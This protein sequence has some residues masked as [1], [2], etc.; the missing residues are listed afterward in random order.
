MRKAL[1]FTVQGRSG[2]ANFADANGFAEHPAIAEALVLDTPYLAEDIRIRDGV[3]EA[4]WEA[5]FPPEV[6]G[7]TRL[8][9]PVHR[10]ARCVLLAACSG[11][12]VDAS[13]L[14]RATLHAAAHTFYDR[15][16]EL[17]ADAPQTAALTHREA[18]VLHWTRNGKTGSEIA[19]I[20]GISART[21]RYHL[22]NVKKK[23]DVGSAL[24]AVVK[25]SGNARRTD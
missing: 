15:W 25:L 12:E 3:A 17:A 24:Q 18:E 10:G 2:L 9:L 4:D 7:S 5:T 20:T 8:K 23:L 14:A 13:P 19:K 11:R 16:M 21:V 6:R 1:V 22:S